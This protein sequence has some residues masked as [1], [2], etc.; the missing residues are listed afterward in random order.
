MATQAVRA[1]ETGRW[2]RMALGILLAMSAVTARAATPG[3]EACSQFEIV[4]AAGHRAAGGTDKAVQSEARAVWL[5][6]RLIQWSGIA[7]SGARFKLYHSAS[8]GISA[9]A[10]ERVAGADGMLMLDVRTDPPP[11]AIGA[12][13]AWLGDG[14][15]LGLK[16][17]DQAFLPELLRR[18][19]VLV[20]ED[21]AGKVMAATSLQLAG[22]LDDLYAAANGVD[23]LGV[24]VT[25]TG[26]RFRLWAPTAQHVALCLYDRGSHHATS[27]EDMRF[28]AATGT[29]S[30]SKAADLSGGYYRYAVQVI[31]SNTQR[32]TNL[33]TDPYSISLSADSALSYI[34]DPASA[35]LKPQGWERQVRPAKVASQTDMSVYELHVRD[36]SI[37]DET[38][39]EAHRGK[40][41]AFTDSTSNGMRH[42]KALAD[43]GLTDIHLL[44]V[45]DFA[46]VPERNCVSPLVSGGPADES[47][48]AAIARVAD[49]D[50]FNWGYDPFHYNAPE[51]SYATD[52]SDGA[53][54]IVEFRRMVMALHRAGLRVGMDVVYNHTMKSGRHKFS[55]LDR[56]VP[57]Y[58]HRLNGKGEVEQSTCCDNTATENMMMGKLMIDSVVSWATHYKIDS[59]RF[60]LM[61]HQPRAVM[62]TLQ[63]KV[64]AA[65]GRHINLIGEGWNFGEV[66]DGRRF[67]QASQLSLN[68][69]GIGTFSDRTRDAVR[70]G[71]AGDSGMDLVTKQGWINGLVD[72]PNAAAGVH[73]R[74]E[75]LRTADMVRVGL[76]G[77][78]RDYRVV[79][80]EGRE[81]A[82]QDIVYGGNQPA[83]YVT[84]PGEV[85]NYVENHDNQTLFDIN[86]FKLPVATGTEDRARVQ[87]LGAAVVAFSQG[88]AYYHA[89]IDT[90]RSKSLDRN[91]FNSGDWFNRIDWSCRDNYF[92][93][94]APR[95]EDN[96]KDYEIIKPLLANPAIKPTPQDIALARDMFRDLLR[97]RASSTLF[98][99]R[100]AEDIRQR[101]RFY[102]TGPRQNP[103][104]M[105]AHV[106]GRN[107]PGARFSDVM[108][109]INAGKTGQ[110][111]VIPEEKGKRYVLHP[112]HRARAAADKRPVEFARY[113]ADGSFEIPARTAVVFVR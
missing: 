28:D 39:P 64:D 10:G 12:R 104:V 78:I 108:Y 44:P 19:V 94:G 59:F 83:G 18:Q 65:T 70:G 40:Y 36:F 97:I 85:V 101:L 80:F 71:G 100:T 107:Y 112:V 102:N 87:M 35:A 33:V 22:A 8:A 82:L 16:D 6:R 79:T 37:N 56:I 54:R 7:P 106:D 89:G 92:G 49:S 63:K 98:R 29:W 30:V 93:T 38:V 46:T 105:A 113:H 14:I 13:F 67:V 3:I 90:L 55:V 58:Y 111:L 73:P 25:H 4:D 31:M 50:C 57:G 75:V 109:F 20:Q 43:A 32:M 103:A 99:L 84:Q 60:D 11:A 110:R 1:K 86:V 76:A 26:T 9:A 15:V 34:G 24:K 41:L 88:V 21:E 51:G 61:A 5:N 42:L 45:F 2:R 47:Q 23:D 52:A 62:E 77:S 95:K 48:Q 17:A 96:G 66:A 72:D 27:I 81:A 53:L 68:G 69:S 74:E 91:S